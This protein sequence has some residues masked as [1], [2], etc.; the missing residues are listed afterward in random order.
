[1]S[2]FDNL[3]DEFARQSG[4]PLDWDVA[5]VAD[6]ADARGEKGRHVLDRVETFYRRFVILPSEHAYVAVTLWAAH[7]HALDDF[8]TTPRLAALS[9]EPGSGKTRL[10]EVTETLVPQPMATFNVSAAVLYR[11]MSEREDGTQRRPT[12]LLD[13]ADTIFGPRASKDHEDLRGFVNSG[14]RRGATAQRCAMHGKTVVIEEFPSFAAVCI[15]GLDDLP[16][17]IMTRSIVI[18]MQRRA[19]HE[20]VEPY[21]RR[22]VEPQGHLLRDDLTEWLNTVNLDGYFPEMPPGVEDRD[23]DCWEPLI[24]IADKA[25]GDWPQRAREAA[26]HFV[27]A[28]KDNSSQSLNVRLLGDL[29]TV[30]DTIGDD[31]IPT[32]TLLEHLTSM[33]ESPWADLRG[34]PL[35]SRGL[36]RRLAKYQ[37][38]PVQ[39]RVDDKNLRGYRRE[40]LH[41]VWL[42]Y[43]GESAVPSPPQ[44]PA[45]SATSATDGRIEA[46]IAA[47]AP[48][49]S[50]CRTTVGIDAGQDLCRNCRRDNERKTQ[51]KENTA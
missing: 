16:D 45:T 20:T 23:A 25:G 26:V 43:L 40:D 47:V 28:G 49:C 48:R 36:S 35:D 4:A 24:A 29:R 51:R 31:H 6:V 9:P 30:F 42:R 8:D 21:R 3:A 50:E 11:S 15:A 13:E 22:L 34:K 14:Y 2:T 44:V 10:Q 17:T 27:S 41:D 32:A 18:R 37:V 19:P 7:T 12:I 1:M 5:D 38:K 39:L 33:E 46:E